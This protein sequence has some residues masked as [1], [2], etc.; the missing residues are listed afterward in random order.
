MASN[1]KNS[2]AVNPLTSIVS[3]GNRLDVADHE[4]DLQAV[5]SHAISIGEIGSSLSAA[6]KYFILK[7]INLEGLLSLD[8]LPTVATFM[9]EKIENL[10]EAEAVEILKEAIVEHDGDV[11]IPSEVYE[12]FEKL[13]E[14]APQMID[15]GGVKDKLKIHLEKDEG[16]EKVHQV[17]SDSSTNLESAESLDSVVDWSLQVRLE[18]ALIAYWSPYTEVRSVTDPFDDPSIPVETVRVYI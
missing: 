16:T 17:V 3:T 18:A 12:L 5:A 8:D 11:N 7:R 1:E 14:M 10:S 9:I 15:E 2:L 6:Q 13:V 4:I